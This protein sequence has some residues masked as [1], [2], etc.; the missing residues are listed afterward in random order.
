MPSVVYTPGT[1]VNVFASTDLNA[2]ADKSQKTSSLA[3]FDNTAGLPLAQFELSLAALSPQANARILAILVPE[4]QTPGTTVTGT[5]GTNDALWYRWAQYPYAIIQLTRGTTAAQVQRSR[6]FNIE[7]G[8]YRAAAI[9][10][11]GAPLATTGNMLALR[12][13]TEQTTT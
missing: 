5:D 2:L 12:A 9:N 6:V 13:F 8:K 11:S 1:W 4:T 7:N 3:L 10:L